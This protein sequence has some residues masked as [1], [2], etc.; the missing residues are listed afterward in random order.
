MMSSNTA[1]TGNIN[2]E[3]GQ[4]GALRQPS[5]SV[6]FTIAEADGGTVV[7]ADPTAA[8]GTLTVTLGTDVG[9]GFFCE[10]TQV[11]AGTVTFAAGAGTSIDSAG[12]GPSLTA[13]WTS[14]RLRRRS[15]GN[16][17]VEGSVS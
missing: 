9:P 12:A 14:A 8:G 15:N 17:I 13:E 7:E 11:T 2:G 1:H 6:D 3:N 10:V 5:R 16:W 4:T